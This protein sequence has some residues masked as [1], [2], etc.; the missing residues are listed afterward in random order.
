MNPVAV[1]PFQTANMHSNVKLSR[2]T[3]S[4]WTA[5]PITFFYIS[6]HNSSVFVFTTLQELTCHRS[7]RI[8]PTY[9]YLSSAH[10][11]HGIQPAHVQTSRGYYA[12]S[13]DRKQG[14]GKLKSPETKEVAGEWRNKWW[15]PLLRG[16]QGTCCMSSR[17]LGTQWCGDDVLGRASSEQ[18]QGHRVDRKLNAPTVPCPQTNIWMN[19]S[20]AA[21]TLKK[22]GN[23]NQ[24]GAEAFPVWPLN[25]C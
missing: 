10:L 9:L 1:A 21:P 5:K 7:P 19:E 8:M 15:L 20:S 4:G 12:S 22:E 6:M 11:I 18:S 16:S 17:C 3:L 25:F 2:K 14:T 23:T 13:A 24:R